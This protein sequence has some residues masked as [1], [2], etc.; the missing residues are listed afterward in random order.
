LICE[1]N[2]VFGSY[3][4]LVTVTEPLPETVST[5]AEPVPFFLDIGSNKPPYAKR[6]EKFEVSGYTVTYTCHAL[7]ASVV[8]ELDTSGWSWV[9]Q[10]IT[11]DAQS[12]QATYG[13][14]ASTMYRT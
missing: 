1:P 7:G 10:Y 13:P 11:T 2:P 14:E 9:A 3:Q 6:A 12:T 4:A 8:G 5:A